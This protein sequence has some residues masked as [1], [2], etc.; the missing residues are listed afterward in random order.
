MADAAHLWEACSVMYTFLYSLLLISLPSQKKEEIEKEL[1]ASNY[2]S[3]CA[4]HIAIYIIDEIL[5]IQSYSTE[6]LWII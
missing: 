1:A 2:F 6:I 4:R 5:L 3:N